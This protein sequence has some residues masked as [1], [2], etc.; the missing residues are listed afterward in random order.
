MITARSIQKHIINSLY[1]PVEDKRIKLY[2][3]FIVSAL[4]FDLA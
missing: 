3:F 4:P 1:F 2:A